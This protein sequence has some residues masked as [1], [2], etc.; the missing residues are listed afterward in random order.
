MLHDGASGA[1]GLEAP[2]G[3]WDVTLLEKP[4]VTGRIFSHNDF[5]AVYAP[6]AAVYE[7][8]PGLLLRLN[9]RGTGGKTHRIARFSRLG[10]SLEREGFV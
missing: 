7:A 8:L 1:T 9:G 6:R 3:A 2:N 10:Q 4:T 5:N